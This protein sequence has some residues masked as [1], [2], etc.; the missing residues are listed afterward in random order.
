MAQQ[1]KNLP[2]M[3]A[4]QAMVQSVGREPSLEEEMATHSSTL[5]HFHPPLCHS[6]DCHLHMY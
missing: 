2:G 6:A 1:L 4:T 3:Q 5:G